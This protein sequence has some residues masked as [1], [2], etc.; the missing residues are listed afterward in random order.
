MSCLY[1][2]TRIIATKHVRRTSVPFRGGTACVSNVRGATAC[3]RRNFFERMCEISY[4]S[5]P[6]MWRSSSAQTSFRLAN[7]L[8]GSQKRMRPRCMHLFWRAGSDTV[9]IGLYA[10][11]LERSSASIPRAKTDAMEFMRKRRYARCIVKTLLS[12][13]V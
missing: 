5:S 10:H 11:P 6:F 8:Q 1:R 7:L 2:P 3:D 9:R 12:S 13:R 4:L